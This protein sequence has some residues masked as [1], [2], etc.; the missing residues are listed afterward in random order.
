ML[1][2]V[3]PAIPHLELGCSWNVQTK[4]KQ[5]PNR[6]NTHENVRHGRPPSGQSTHE[7]VKGETQME[8]NGTRWQMASVPK[9]RNLSWRSA[10]RWIDRG[11]SDETRRHSAAADLFSPG[12]DAGK[13]RREKKKK[14]KKKEYES[15]RKEKTKNNKKHDRFPARIKSNRDLIRHTGQR[16]LHRVTQVHHG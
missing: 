2:I 10:A 12:H 13:G 8:Q 3:L 11:F 5:S 15:K 7:C 4:S 1:Q 6:K 14:K 9:K 16:S